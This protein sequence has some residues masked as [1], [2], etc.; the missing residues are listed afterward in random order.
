MKNYLELL[1]RVW[2]LPENRNKLWDCRKNKL[3]PVFMAKTANKG[4]QAIMD[5]IKAIGHENNNCHAN[6]N[7]DETLF[8]LM[9]NFR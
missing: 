3:P 6:L 9:T 2:T 8:R 7:S 5:F 1:Y 4:A